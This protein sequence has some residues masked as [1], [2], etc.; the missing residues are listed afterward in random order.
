MKQAARALLLLLACLGAGCEAGDPGGSPDPL[1]SP[2][3]SP[4]PEPSPSPS[5]S[6]TPS[7]AGCFIPD[8]PDCDGCCRKGGNKSFA[9]PVRDAIDT[10]RREQPELF[11]S[12]DGVK[13][14][15]GFVNGVVKELREMGLCAV[16]GG[17]P[18]EVGVKETNEFSEQYDIHTSDRK[19]RYGGLTVTCR[20]PRF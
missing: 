2:S 20:P 7:A 6:P 15:D 8:L 3:P 14:L 4:S 11:K 16:R 10:V 13:D 12:G 18:D 19:V 9:G 5:P 17:P 1:P